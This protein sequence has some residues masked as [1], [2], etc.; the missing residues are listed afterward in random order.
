MT[1]WPQWWCVC[2][3][4]QNNGEWQ[5]NQSEQQKG[6]WDIK[7]KAKVAQSVCV[8][9]QNGGDMRIGINNHRVYEA[10]VQWVVEAAKNQPCIE[11]I[12]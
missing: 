1:E 10:E 9:G 6:V 7:K 8:S 12:V 11:Y 5:E 4:G 3:C 2:V